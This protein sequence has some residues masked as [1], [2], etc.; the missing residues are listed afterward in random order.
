VAVDKL[1]TADKLGA[2]DIRSCEEGQRH[3]EA[4]LG[5][6]ETSDG[7]RQAFAAVARTDTTIETLIRRDLAAVGYTADTGLTAFTDGCSGLRSIL[8]D[9]GVTAAPFLDWLHIAMRLR[10]I[11]RSSIMSPNMTITSEDENPDRQRGRKS[12]TRFCAS[13][14]CATC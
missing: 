5:S 9:A 14:C 12:L 13:P 2:A 7:S 8:D 4:C 1:T 10:R 6:V 11:A 3:L